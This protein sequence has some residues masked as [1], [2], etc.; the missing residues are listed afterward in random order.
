MTALT[1]SPLAPNSPE[2][3]SKLQDKHPSRLPPPTF[4]QTFTPEK[5][6]SPLQLSEKEVEMAIKAFHRGS[7]GGAMGLRPEHLRE[8]FLV[9]ADSRAKPLAAI[10]ELVNLL[11]AG[12]ANPA[13]QQF[14]AGARL[15]ALQKGAHDVRPIAVGET[16][17]RLASKGACAAVKSKA[18]SLF[19]GQQFGVVTAAGSE[20]IIHLCRRTIAAHADEPYFALGKIDL[21]NAFNNVSGTAFLSLTLQHFPDLY[22]WVEWCHET[23][24]CLTYGSQTIPSAEGVQQGDPLGPLLFSL[25]IQYLATSVI[26]ELPEELPLHVWYLDDG[27]LAGKASL[28]RHALD[29]IAH[30]G[31]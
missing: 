15:C 11:L 24:S 19:Q 29:V 26:N 30:E 31:K 8:A 12:K 22:K 3:L 27:V 1:A 5:S 9:N 28:I 23:E 18:R 21:S 10:T 17:R 2:T 13:C 16:I 25:A 14:F 20:I 4:T 7:S 6:H